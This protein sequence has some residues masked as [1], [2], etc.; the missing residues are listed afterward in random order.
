MTFGVR[1]VH[2][3]D[4]GP[5]RGLR[6]LSDDV[7]VLKRRP[8]RHAHIHVRA[9]V[10]VQISHQSMR[11][12]RCALFWRGRHSCMFLEIAIFSRLHGDCCM[13]ALKMPPV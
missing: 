6:L 8:P 12:D 1:G 7:R 9:R 2:L 4:L 13:V 11:Q 5:A 10:R 3:H